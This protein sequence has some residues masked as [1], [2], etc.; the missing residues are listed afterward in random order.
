MSPLKVK[1]IGKIFGKDK[2]ELS[3]VLHL[4]RYLSI[5][6]RKATKAT[7]VLRSG[8]IDNMGT[9]LCAINGKF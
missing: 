1:K 3:L 8:V 9:C 6:R 4:K 7:S 2:E 5:G